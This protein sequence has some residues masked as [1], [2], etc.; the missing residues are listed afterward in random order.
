MKKYEFS[1]DRQQFLK[2]ITPESIVRN[3][4]DR[5]LYSVPF[6]RMFDN[7]VRYYRLE[8]TRFNLPDGKTGIVADFKNT[9]EEVRKDQQIQYSL[10]HHAAVIEALARAYD[11]VW[12]IKDMET[13]RF[14]LCRVDQEMEHLLPTRE[15]VKMARFLWYQIV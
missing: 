11:S 7:G 8:F 3:T 10:D 5:L 13:Q 2:A 15:A 9:D 4:E 6:R 1:K 12:I 14:E